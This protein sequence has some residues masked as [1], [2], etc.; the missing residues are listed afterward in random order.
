MID[1]AQKKLSIRKLVELLEQGIIN[2][3]ASK[4]IVASGD[5]KAP[6]VYV[7]GKKIASIGLKVR[8]NC[9]YHGISFN[10]DMDIRPFSYINVCGYQGLKVIQLKDLLKPSNSIDIDKE[11]SV[12]ADFVSL[13][14]EV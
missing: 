3:L 6:G 11:A 2:Y 14:I 8:K 1:L 5:R 7:D 13:A 12:L 4:G 9:T 10:F